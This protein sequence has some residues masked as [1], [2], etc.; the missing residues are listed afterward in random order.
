MANKIS[1]QLKQAIIHASVAPA[2]IEV[3]YNRHRE[4]P[5]L[6]ITQTLSFRKYRR[7]YVSMYLNK[8]IADKLSDLSIVKNISFD[9]KIQQ[10][11]AFLPSFLPSRSITLKP[12]MIPTGTIRKAL[13]GVQ[14]DADN[15]NGK[16]IKFTVI[17]SGYSP[18]NHQFPFRSVTTFS[19]LTR[20]GG[21]IDQSGH[22]T[23]CVSSIGGNPYK[24][25]DKDTIWGMCPKASLTSIRSLFT[26][27]GMG[28]T[29]LTLKGLKMALDRGVQ[30]ISMS[31]GS[32]EPTEK[33]DPLATI[34]RESTK[35]GILYC[36]AAGNY[37]PDKNTISSPGDILE[38]ITVG[39][40]SYTDKTVSFFSSRGP[41]EKGLIKPDILCYGGGRRIESLTPEETLISSSSGMLDTLDRKNSIAGLMGTS[42][43][44]PLHA[45]LL[46]WWQ[47]YSK[48]RTGRYLN[49]D[50]ITKIYKANSTNYNNTHGY[51]L[52]TYQW[53]KEYLR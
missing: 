12:G 8:R 6:S 1:T 32:K 5:K 18:N 2:I 19:A 35:Q 33:D 24:L 45:G 28:T 11:R 52:A 3:E 7:T 37:G 36:I 48:K 40:Q 14:A 41:T 34:I 25:N 51:G 4:L 53:I 29:S 17:D 20:Y 27:T 39:A 31:L 13:G 43:A 26:P 23:W 10:S 30:I 49:R 9:R 46:G 50:D 16:G 21:Q 15:S 44:T 38:A 22:G 47:T 42:M